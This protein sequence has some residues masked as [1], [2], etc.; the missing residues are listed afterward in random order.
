MNAAT[1]ADCADGGQAS[2]NVARP[3]GQFGGVLDGGGGDGEGRN[4]VDGR[5]SCQSAVPCA[6]H[7]TLACVGV[8]LV[9][10]RVQ[11]VPT[12]AHA[13]MMTSNLV[14]CSDQVR[15]GCETSG[16][17]PGVREALITAYA[18]ST[19]RSGR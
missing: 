5:F 10:G 14:A 12:A 6:S 1:S 17:R 18:V 19:V 4:R 16:G 15:I 7:L 2:G 11:G 8:E 3:P 9:G 13:P